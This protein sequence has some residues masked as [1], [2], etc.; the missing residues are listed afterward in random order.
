MPDAGLTFARPEALWLLA[1]TPLFVLSGLVFGVRRR[2]LPRVAVWLRLLVITG[3]ALALA[4]PLLTH[5][6]DA[7]STVFVVDRSRSLTERT[8]EEID[9]WLAAALA[10]AGETD[11]AAIVHF[12]AAPE[13]VAPAG[14][15][16]GLGSSWQ[17]ATLPGQDAEYTNIESALALARALPLGGQRRIVLVSDG[18]Q[19]AGAALTQADQATT[20]RTPIDVVPVAGVTES[21]LRLEGA[22]AAS[23]TW[24]GESL[25]VV[26]SVAT[27]IPGGGAVELWIDGALSER[28]EVELP[29]GI[30]SYTFSAEGLESGF[31]ALEV[32][33]S[34]TSLNDPYP[35]NNVQA[36]SLVV[37]DQPNVLLVTPLGADPA[38]LRGALERRGAEVTAS[39]PAEVPWRLSELS[40][41]DA[42]IL[43]NVAANELTLDQVA[44]LRESTRSGRGL[45]VLGGTASFGPGGY[46]GS[47]LEEALPVTVRVTDGRERERVAVLMIVDKSGSMSYAPGNTPKIDL[48][49]EA[50]G[51]AAQSLADGDQVGILLFND[52]QHWIL[53]LTTIEG[54]AERQLI[55][56][57][58]AGISADGG[59]EIYPALQ[60]G[61]DAIRN[62]DA[63]VRHIILLSDGKSRT[64]TRETY[65]KLIDDVVSDRTTLSTI[66]VGEDAD[67]DLLQFLAEQGNGR[68]HFTERPEDIPRLTLEEAQ[69]AGSQ[70]V[71]RGDFA[72]I[73]TLPSP[74]LRGFDP[75]TLPRLDGY[76]FAEAKAKAQVVLT[77]DR[78]DPVLAKWQ[79]GLG[80]V[81]AW[82]ADDGTDFA[83]AW[84]EWERYDE[85][86][87]SV[88]RW[89]LPDPENRPMAVSVMRDG[90]DA[91]ISVEATGNDGRFADLAA[92]SAT[93]TTP[94]GAVVAD[95]PLY[96]TG[97]GQYQVR[98]AAPEPGA[99]QVELSQTRGNETIVELAGFAVPP[100]PEL[101]PIAGASALMR[102]IAARTGGRLLSLDDPAE[103]FS[104]QGLS[105]GVPR[106]Y[107]PF[108]YLPLGLALLAL[109]AEIAV[110]MRFVPRPVRGR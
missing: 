34:G 78:D 86:W 40:V 26:A 58:V 33:V 77:S 10:A 3:L 31:H 57:A 27:G 4:D 79:Y 49:R 107:Q 88:V 96:Q 52:N 8:G 7:V 75:E 23:S 84:P 93:I 9:T 66:A 60:V 98:V 99:Y 12:G 110:R 91:V 32:R 95:V 38:L 61:F 36:L 109:L 89:S 17:E 41:F 92:T 30:S 102:A 65:Q 90:P 104:A 53:P 81:V 5:G 70:S 83:G 45:I 105:G 47:A 1:L 6:G 108:W 80:R 50:V 35:E 13:L 44:G 67:T 19:N 100:S 2:G 54:A 72:P 56:D 87:A 16:D 20:D 101:R 24:R 73:Q 63:D 46:A 11:R 25:N 94:S 39:V 103:A 42:V 97:P 74:I 28:Q 76:D 18:A 29:G 22:S 71:I 48:A 59:T 51:V 69:S 64:G 62:A 43:N 82:T 55:D 106:D 85:F 37:R 14:P 15:A 21:D 68:Y